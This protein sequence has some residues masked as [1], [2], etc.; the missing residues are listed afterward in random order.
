MIYFGMYFLLLTERANTADITKSGT[1]F[2]AYPIFNA[3]K[4]YIVEINP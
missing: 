3:L 1:L 2:K 4:G